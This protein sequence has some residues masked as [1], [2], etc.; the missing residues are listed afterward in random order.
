MAT[1][2][3]ANTVTIKLPKEKA[4]EEN[5]ITASVNGKL[6][7]IKKGIKVEV[8]REVAEVIAS[9]ER[10]KNEAVDFIESSSNQ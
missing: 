10:A 8:P 2:K 3:L 1:K 5:F 7:Q 4:G 6:Y 9:S